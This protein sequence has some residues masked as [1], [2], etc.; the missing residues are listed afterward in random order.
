MERTL[1]KQSGAVHLEYEKSSSEHSGRCTEFLKCGRATQVGTAAV[2][3]LGRPKSFLSYRVR[4]FNPAERP[5]QDFANA[6]K[7]IV[8]CWECLNK[9]HRMAAIGVADVVF[10]MYVRFHLRHSG[11]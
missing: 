5:A 2:W 3:N 7:L 1:T 11:R 4:R 6:M 10:G 9:F 8:R